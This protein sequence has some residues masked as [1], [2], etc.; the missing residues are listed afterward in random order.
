MNI[1]IENKNINDLFSAVYNPRVALQP[2]MD[3]YEKLKRSIETFGLV[4]PIVFN[5]RTG[6][7]VG[8]HQRITVLKDLGW[9]EVPVSVVDL[10]KEEE[11]ALNVALNKIDG[12]WDN[13]KLKELLEELDDGSFDVTLTGFDMDEIE[14]LM[15]QYY[16]EDETN[17]PTEDDFDVEQNIPENPI[18]KKGDVWQLG[19]HRLM[20]GDSTNE[21]DFQK[22]MG[23]RK[24]A[25][26]FTSP[27]YNA[28]SN[29]L[30]GNSNLVD[31]KYR[32]IDDNNEHYLDLITDFTILCL[33]HSE[34]V[35]VNIQQLA[36]NKL[37][38]IDYFHNFK[39]NFVDMMIWHKKGAAPAMAQNVLNSAFEYIFIFKDEHLP[40][41]TINTGDFR[42]TISNVYEAPG[43]RNNEYKDIHAATFPIH[44]PSFII[45]NF[46]KKN[47]AVIDCFGG[48]GTSLIA[49]E[50][51]GRDCFMMELDPV[52]CDVIV[53]RWEEFTGQ[54]AQL[55]K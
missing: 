49:C 46:T 53:K 24:A 16:V 44:L 20:C 48:T 39:T 47:D 18:T 31:S 6:T 55:L 45:E 4:E 7:V 50:Q 23:D 42:G 25:I 13:F 11:K 37:D 10:S 33:K 54:K 28:G 51:L 22:L 34:Y 35:F 26:T 43:Q 38:V 17:E 41:R 5:E 1:R 36:G 15:T 12:S 27:P 8:G 52:Y 3:E 40:K 2:G 32:S 19:R 9:T 14:D 21:K 29:H 30:G